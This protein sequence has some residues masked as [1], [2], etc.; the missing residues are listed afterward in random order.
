MIGSILNLGIGS[1]KKKNYQN[2][3][4]RLENQL[5]LSKRSDPEKDKEIEIFKKKKKI[6][7]PAKRTFEWTTF[8]SFPCL[9]G[10]HGI[11]I[12]RLKITKRANRS[13]LH[14]L[15]FDLNSPRFCFPKGKNLIIPLLDRG[16][17]FDKAK[18][19]TLDMPSSELLIHNQFDS[20]LARLQQSVLQ[21]FCFPFGVF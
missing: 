8:T 4:F 19:T 11:W 21:I 2:L 17:T 9:P 18:F 20:I 14:L 10:L 3:S 7:P 6:W 12:Y 15:F 16:S 13:S 1:K 5:Q